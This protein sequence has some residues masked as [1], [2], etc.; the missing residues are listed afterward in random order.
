LPGVDSASVQESGQP[1][2][3][4]AGVSQMHEVA[5]GAMLSLGSGHY[6][7]TGQ[8]KQPM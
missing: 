2:G 1:A 5:T 6:V 4:V 8:I 3:S 7:L